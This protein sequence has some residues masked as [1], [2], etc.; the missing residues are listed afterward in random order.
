MLRLDASED[1]SGLDAE[2]HTVAVV[3]AEEAGEG[4]EDVM[5]FLS[6]VGVVERLP[7]LAEACGDAGEAGDVPAVES[8]HVVLGAKIFEA[9]RALVRRGARFWCAALT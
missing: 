2:E 9:A 3:P 8:D 6:P 7:E 4:S 5:L 1:G